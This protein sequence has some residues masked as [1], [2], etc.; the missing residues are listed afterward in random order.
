MKLCVWTVRSFHCLVCVAPFE[1]L[2]LGTLARIKTKNPRLKALT[3]L[4]QTST[5]LTMTPSIVP[6]DD[7]R[8]RAD[9]SARPFAS[10]RRRQNRN[11]RPKCIWVSL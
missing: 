4:L 8:V 11:L 5:A 6:R 7:V 2:T 3:V 10:R 1:I 9:A